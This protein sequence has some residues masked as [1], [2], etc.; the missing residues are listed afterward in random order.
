MKKKIIFSIAFLV[1]AGTSVFIVVSA[2]GGIAAKNQDTTSATSTPAVSDL[3]LERA[4]GDG[5]AGADRSFASWAG[6]L[7]SPSTL[8]V[9]SLSE[10]VLTGFE[11]RV[12]QRVGKGAVIARLSSPPA[13]VERANVSAER[14]QSIIRARANAQ[15]TI[16]LAE[17]TKK[18]LL[19]ER[20][21]L[22]NSKKNVLE[23]IDS[24]S[25]VTQY[26]NDNSFLEYDRLKKEKEEGIAYAVRERDAA[27]VQQELKESTLRTKLRQIVEKNISDF[28]T[29]FPDIGTLRKNWVLRFKSGAGSY[30]QG[31]IDY[32]RQLETVIHDLEDQYSSLEESALAYAKVARNFVYASSPSE[33]IMPAEIISWKKMANDD[34]SMIVDIVNM[35]RE[36]KQMVNV[37]DAEVA[38]KNAERDKELTS[39]SISVGSSKLRSTSTESARKKLHSDTELEYLAKER[40]IDTKISELEREKNVARAEVVATESSYKTFFAELG[41]QTIIAPKAGIVSGISKVVGDYVTPDQII[42]SISDTDQMDFFI[43]FRVPSDA[44]LPHEGDS[45]FVVRPGFPFD[46]QEAV[47]SGIGKTLDANG[48]FVAEAEFTADVDWPINALVRVMDVSAVGRMLVPFTAIRWDEEK[49]P[50]IIIQGKDKTFV[51]RNVITGKA[52]GDRVEVLEGLLLGEMYLAKEIP[53]EKLEGKLRFEDSMPYDAGSASA[54]EVMEDMDGMGDELGSGGGHSGG[55]EHGE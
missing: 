24:E 32:E 16:A 21:S 48:S 3:P 42:A 6:E 41:S 49:R 53:S 44:R 17:S 5:M 10:G 43:R 39:S 35:I 1:V 12:G 14:M 7:I 38:K 51:D 31:S 15:S 33:D 54:D 27:R 50:H 52:I 40:E 19:K 23:A 46:K 18:Q 2:R 55:H 29:N 20:A 11:V 4:Q 8:E 45:V 22:E 28:T 13:S 37:K 36:M 9:H 47:V 25:K 30:G 34:Q 26:I